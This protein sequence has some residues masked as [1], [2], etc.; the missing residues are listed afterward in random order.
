VP[1]PS[2]VCSTGCCAQCSLAPPPPI[3]HPAGEGLA[4]LVDGKE[5]ASGDSPP[6]LCG[7][8]IR[9]TH[10]TN[11]GPW[12]VPLALSYVAVAGLAVAKTVLP[13]K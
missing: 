9:G 13:R 2:A 8:A 10:R 11:V 3:R 1:L 6:E 4:D 12:F 5:Y 7:A